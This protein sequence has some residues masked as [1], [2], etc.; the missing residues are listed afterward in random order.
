M[1]RKGGYKI[2][3]LKGNDLTDATF[4]I[5]GIYEA[6]EGNYNKAI[7]L[8]GI[9]INDV[10]YDDVFTTPKVVSSKYVLDAYGYT[11]TIDD[12]DLVTMGVITTLFE[13]IVDKDGN[14]RFVEGDGE[15]LSSDTNITI[16]YNKWSLSGSHLM[17]VVT[18]TI[19]SG[20]TMSVDALHIKYVLPE[21]INDKIYPVI[22]ANYLKLYNENAFDISGNIET[23]GVIISKSNDGSVHFESYGN[24]S[25]ANDDGFRIQF[26]L[27]IDNE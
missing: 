23:F 1:N 15:N 21:W 7:L 4:T 27:L 16:T 18:G 5:D 26:D 10:E 17:L 3:D 2:I 11:L 19:P 25:I 9:V 13:N 20:S 24:A 6:L 12:D 8:T 22:G 14:N